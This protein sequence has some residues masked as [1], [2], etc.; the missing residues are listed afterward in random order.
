MGPAKIFFHTK[1]QDARL[2]KK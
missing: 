2:T 1:E